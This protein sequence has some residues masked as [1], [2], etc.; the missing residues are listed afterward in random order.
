MSTCQ[1]T[2]QST[3]AAIAAL[4]PTESNFLRRTFDL[5]SEIDIARIMRRACEAPAGA[6]SE[7]RKV[8]L[9]ALAMDY[10]STH[11]RRPAV[12]TAIQSCIASQA[13]AAERYGTCKF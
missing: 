8:K 4:P 5:R 11:L 1:P 13:R 2:K 3:V 7:P 9:L 12:L 10:E 6:K